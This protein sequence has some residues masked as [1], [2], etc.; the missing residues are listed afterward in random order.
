MVLDDEWVGAGGGVLSAWQMASR[1]YMK[2]T[3]VIIR[4]CAPGI[5]HHY[6]VLYCTILDLLISQPLFTLIV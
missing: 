5:F 6:S 3:R 1:G 2:S 4:A